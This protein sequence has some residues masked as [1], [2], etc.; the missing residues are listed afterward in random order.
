MKVSIF[1]GQPLSKDLTTNAEQFF[2]G[3]GGSLFCSAPSARK[4]SIGKPESGG[5]RES[6]IITVWVISA[7]E[8]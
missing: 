5:N 2:G 8:L 7:L 6:N 1:H 4:I 3:V